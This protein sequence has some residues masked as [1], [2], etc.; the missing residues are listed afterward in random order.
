M[1]QNRRGPQ[2]ALPEWQQQQQRGQDASVTSPKA[3]QHAPVTPS[4]LRTPHFPGSSPEDLMSSRDENLVPN[5]DGEGGSEAQSP[6]TENYERN[7]SF[8]APAGSP[9]RPQGHYR[10]AS[11]PNVRTRL[12]GNK[13]SEQQTDYGT[14]QSRRSSQPQSPKGSGRSTGVT[15]PNGFGGIQT[16]RTL[17]DEQDPIHDALGDA[18]TDGLLGGRRH[19]KPTAT[20][21]L[22]KRHGIKH[23]RMM[24]GPFKIPRLDF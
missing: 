24:Y 5:R 4:K 22:A 23:S 18:V 12:L 21:Y 6:K 3:I 14:G 8:Q 15:S 9:T 16:T 17:A 7:K 2:P 13:S 1:S 20:Q 10:Q 11:E 19:N